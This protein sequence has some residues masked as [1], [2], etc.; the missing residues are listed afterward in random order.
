MK[1]S[2]I[3]H[4]AT[5]A[6]IVLF[7]SGCRA[8]EPEGAAPIEIP[9]AY[10]QAGAEL[11]QCAQRSAN[12]EPIRFWKVKGETFACPKGPVCAGR[13]QSPHHVYI[14]ERWIDNPSLVKH[15][16]L[17]DLLNTGEHPVAIFGPEGCNVLWDP[18]Q[19]STGAGT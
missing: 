9:A 1:A 11:E 16:M 13:W 3:R 2:T 14:A 17:H 15:E 4:A 12:L 10:R 8:F 5:L 19:T 18:P 6:A 7:C